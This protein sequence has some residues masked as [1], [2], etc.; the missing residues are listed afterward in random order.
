MTDTCFMCPKPV[1]H[2]RPALVF[3]CCLN[4]AEYDGWTQMFLKSYRAYDPGVDHDSVIVFNN[5][6]STAEQRA[7]FE[8]MPNVRFIEHDNSGWDIGAHLEASRWITNP[9][10]CYMGNTAFVQHAGWLARLAQAWDKHGPGVYGTLATFEVCPHLNT[11]GFATSPDFMR[12]YPISVRSKMNRYDFE[13]GPNAFWKLVAAEG[14][15]ALLVTWCGEYNWQHWR[16]PPNIYRRGTQSNCV[17]FFRHS[18]N[19][20]A[21]D[22]NEK[23]TMEKLAD[24]ITSLPFTAESGLHF[25][26]QQGWS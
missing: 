26:Q 16:L 24:T 3:T 6:P 13:H 11:T 9:W 1:N 19:Y 18:L 4:N 10:A 8:F 2:G 12:R 25:L 14:H 23:R 15:P 7:Q 5:G 17:T 20:A 22:E 21:A